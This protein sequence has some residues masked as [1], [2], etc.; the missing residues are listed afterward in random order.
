M[1]REVRRALHRLTAG[2]RLAPDRIVVLSAHGKRRSIVWKQRTFGNL[3][4]VEHPKPP[5]PGEVAFSSLHRFK[6]LEA[7]V[8][9][10]CEVDPDQATF[11]DKHMYVGCSRAKHVL[12][13]LKYQAG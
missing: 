6:G 3:R 1:L 9:L 4:L 2:D 5:G 8:I 13:V 12:F 11:T 7:D 10:L